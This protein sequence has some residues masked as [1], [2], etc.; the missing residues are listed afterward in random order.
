MWVMCWWEM[1]GQGRKN[2]P[3]RVANLK[4]KSSHAVRPALF[5][6]FLLW[7]SSHIV[8]ERNARAHTPKPTRMNPLL[9]RSR[10]Q[11]TDRHRNLLTSFVTFGRF[12]LHH[13]HATQPSWVG[14]FQPSAY[15][16]S[17]SSVSQSQC[18]GGRK[19]WSQKET[20]TVKGP[21]AFVLPYLH[22]TALTSGVSHFGVKKRLWL[23]QQVRL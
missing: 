16:L 15:I 9:R 21:A 6:L 11:E 23:L 5:C 10:L 7:G 17:S 2:G 22:R 4:H 1:G 13:A 14:I 18:W 19:G 3:Q 12:L 8:M 20:L